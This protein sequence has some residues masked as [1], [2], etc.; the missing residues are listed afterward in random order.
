MKSEYYRMDRWD[1]RGL[2]WNNHGHFYD[3][4]E[5]AKKNYERFRSTYRY[6][7]VKVT[8]EVIEDSSE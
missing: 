2:N 6:R 5:E 4:P 8:I 3:T 1:A 7:L